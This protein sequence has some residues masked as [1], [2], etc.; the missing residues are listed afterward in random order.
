LAT[1]KKSKIDASPQKNSLHP[2]CTHLPLLTDT[3]TPTQKQSQKSAIAT[4]L[5]AT[6]KVQRRFEKKSAKRN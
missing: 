1:A 6:W 4:A 2:H 5:N 3:Q